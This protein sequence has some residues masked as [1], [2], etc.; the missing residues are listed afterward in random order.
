MKLSEYQKKVPETWI[1][2]DFDLE[3]IVLGVV[4]EAGEVA[5]LFKKAYRGDYHNKLDRF[6]DLLEREIGDCTFYLAHLCNF[7]D[8]DYEDILDKNIAK[9]QKRKEEGKI[10]G[11]GSD[12]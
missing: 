9:L 4:G 2:N 1:C 6:R 10:K 12:R 3:R 5:E 7:Y 11:T 8:L